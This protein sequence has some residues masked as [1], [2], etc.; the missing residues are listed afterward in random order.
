MEK[1]I[2]LLNEY[3]KSERN[4][5]PWSYEDYFTWKTDFERKDGTDCE[6]FIIS[7]SY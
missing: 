2:E 7:K 1:L 3:E 4:R 5:T 6:R